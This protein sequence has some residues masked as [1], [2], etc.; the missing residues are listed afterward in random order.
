MWRRNLLVGICSI[1]LFGACS[2][3]VTAPAD[4]VEFSAVVEEFLD[5]PIAPEAIGG[6]LVS[7]PDQ[8]EPDNR[9]I[10][11]ILVSTIIVRRSPTGKL[12]PATVEDI[13]VGQSAVFEI[14]NAELRSDPLQVFATRIE[15]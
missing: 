6:I 12:I 1:T 13:E 4:T 5:V 15:L 8:L 11:H 2:S 14:D 3:E 9:S 7:H 10:I